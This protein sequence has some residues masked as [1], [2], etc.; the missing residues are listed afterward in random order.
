MELNGDVP[1]LY[2]RQVARWPDRN[3]PQVSPVLKS[4]AAYRTI[5][6]SGP[7]AEALKEARD[8]LPSELTPA[9]IRS[10][11]ILATADGGYWSYQTLN[12]AWNA[13]KVRST[14]TATLIRKDP[15]TGEPVKVQEVKQ[16]GDTI[17][18]H[19]DIKVTIDFPVTPHILRHTF[20]TRCI[21][22]GMD[23][24]RVQY[25]A[26]HSTPTLTL[27]I[28]TTLMANKPEDLIDDIQRI[29]GK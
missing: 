28:Y 20:I 27:Q 18:K 12:R 16:L 22:G 10:R 5:P 6:L 3:Q 1:A 15:K 19:P 23:V 13:V 4:D 24:K 9:Q 17:P 11:P 26:G 8:A 7:L 25:L 2:V 14:G 21:L 29:F